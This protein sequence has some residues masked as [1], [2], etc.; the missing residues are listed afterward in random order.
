MN[1]LSLA[2]SWRDE[3]NTLSLVMEILNNIFNAI[4]TIEAIIKISGLGKTY[5]KDNWN[6]FDLAIVIGTYIGLLIGIIFKVN[7]G[8]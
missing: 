6:I 2:I 1:T 5:F 3:P 8:P 7:I 4:F